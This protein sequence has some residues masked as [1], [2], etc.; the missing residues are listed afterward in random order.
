MDDFDENINDG[1]RVGD[2]DER[3]NSKSGRGVYDYNIDDL[4]LSG[5]DDEE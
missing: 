5:D 3:D 2:G 1:N 4:F